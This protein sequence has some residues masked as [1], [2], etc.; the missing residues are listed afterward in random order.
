[1]G[2]AEPDL[3]LAIVHAPRGCSQSDPPDCAG[4]ATTTQIGV[5]LGLGGRISERTG[6]VLR[7]RIE[8]QAVTGDGEN[9][10]VFGFLG[11]GAYRTF[12]PDAKV[13]ILGGVGL[14]VTGGQVSGGPT[15]H[16]RYTH[17]V[18]RFVG[19]AA[20]AATVFPSGDRGLGLEASVALVLQLEDH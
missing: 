9:P 15:V 14:T 3:V 4:P 7:S 13:E 12:G 5:G 8:R 18:A 1:M 17:H 11:V 19:G 6:L 2:F 16:V 10:D 20:Q